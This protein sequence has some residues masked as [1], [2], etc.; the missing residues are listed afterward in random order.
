MSDSDGLRGFIR[1]LSRPEIL[2]TCKKCAYSWKT[3]RYYTKRHATG[4]AR[5]DLGAGSRD[6][7]MDNPFNPTH[8][9]NMRGP[10]EELMKDEAVFDICPKCE[11]KEFSQKRIWR[12]SKADYE[13]T[14]D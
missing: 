3:P 9:S 4:L 11:S 8:L 12:E 6:G 5:P 2:R 14:D 13:G 1:A 7:Y 10:N